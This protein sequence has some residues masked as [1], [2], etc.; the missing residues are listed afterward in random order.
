MKLSVKCKAKLEAIGCLV[1]RKREK[2]KA[3]YCQKGKDEEEQKSMKRRE[4]ME[5]Y[6]EKRKGALRGLQSPGL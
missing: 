5:K 2:R 1:K 3:N 6:R 4:K